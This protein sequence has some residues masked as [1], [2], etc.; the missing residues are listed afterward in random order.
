M[1][2]WALA[3]ETFDVVPF[4]YLP[5]F[6]LV[7]YLVCTLFYNIYLSP[8]SKFPGPK[9][10]VCTDLLS[11][12]WTSTGQYHY[13][14]KDLHDTYGD[15]VRTGPSTLIY[16][17]VQ[18]WKDIYGH[19]K[20]GDLS[21]AKDPK[22]Y[23]VGPTGPTL[24]NANDADHSRERRLLS[25]CF[26]EK[27]LREQEGLIQSYADLLVDRLKGEIAA[28]R[29]TVDMTQWYNFTTFDIIGD[30]AFGEPFDCLRDKLYHPW[31]KTTFTSSK[32]AMIQRPLAMYPLLAPI[33]K[34]FI[35]K[36]LIQTRTN[37]FNMSAEKVARRLA[38]KTSRPD[39]M[40]YIL[41]Y[42]GDRSMTEREMKAN[43]GVLILAGS[44][45]TATLLSGFTFHILANPT[46][47]QKLVDEISAF[48]S[49][50]EITFQSVSQLTYLNAAL[51]ESLRIYPPIP[52]FLSRIVP[53]G[54]ALIDGHFIPE[55]VTVAGAH[56]STYH[57]K[58]HFAEADSFIPERW[59]DNRDERFESDCRSALQPFSLGPRNCLGKNLAYAEIRLIAAK[60]LWSFD[61]TLDEA[62]SGWNI[63]RSFHI[64]E[65]PPLMV[66]L[67]E[68][69]H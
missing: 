69:Q 39:F 35:S 34:Q 38:T 10:A 54:G 56:Y 66:K 63:Q 58:D 41:Q 22:L 5:V 11:I 6:A 21:F 59:L 18:G 50:D 8:L 2:S 43:A 29:E 23:L 9:L 26:S 12:Y 19:R 55:G 30:L 52:G 67:S 61:M 13:K 57:S 40:S 48:K 45:T 15:V 49:K 64:W 31:V 17:S 3:D 32:A 62:S 65:K 42:T 4:L 7:T 24:I 20:S 14:L 25:H 28:S 44:E 47:Y 51:E 33:L 16:R 27:A 1:V 46:T 68:A 36:K 60:L 53:Q 37:H